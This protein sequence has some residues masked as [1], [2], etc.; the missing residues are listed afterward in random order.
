M[1]AT[2]SLTVAEGAGIVRLL[3]RIPDARGVAGGGGGNVGSSERTVR[4]AL[5]GSAAFCVRDASL[6]P[7]FVE[8]AASSRFR[9]VV[10]MGSPLQNK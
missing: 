10:K 7:G 2:T 9:V 3:E 5:S 1:S 4:A 6:C 8:G